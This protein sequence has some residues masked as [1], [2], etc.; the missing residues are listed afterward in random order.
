MKIYIVSR[1]CPDNKYKTFGIF[2]L[3]QAKAL[4][5]AGCDVV[6]LAV[7]VRSLRRWRKWG[8][9]QKKI[10]NVNIFIYSLPL[11]KIPDSIKYFISRIIL[12]KMYKKAVKLFGVP[13]VIHAHFYNMGYIAAK[14]KYLDKTPLVITEHSSKIHN[15]T[16][17]TGVKQ[18][19][20]FGYNKAS[21]VISVS[22]SVADHINEYFGMP[23][24]VIPN[25]IDTSIFKP[26]ELK[27]NEGFRFVCT[28]SLTKNKALDTLIEAFAK[29]FSE[30]PQVSLTIFGE[31]E[32]RNELEALIKRYKLEKQIKLPGLAERVD[33]A[34]VLAQSD[35][36]ILVSLSETFGVAYIEALAAG[37]P[38]IAA[39]CGGPED[40]INDENG[41]FVEKGD[42]SQT[43]SAMEYM[44]NNPGKY[45]KQ[46]ISEYIKGRY[47]GEIIAAQ[48][49]ECYKNVLETKHK[50]YKSCNSAI[51]A[52]C[53]N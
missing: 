10:D 48:L 22:K 36:F 44:V 52:G 14:S 47:S 30:C 5:K 11:G 12:D 42:I 40:F 51:S 34:K 7:D 27:R 21:C 35:C 46:T 23:S 2:E 33:I 1:G 26:Y 8:W 37:L 41:L 43:A 50:T 28:A 31:G 6:L 9:Q 49:I 15:T 24:V 32:M 29:A 13:D 18:Q 16:E 25:T 38:V 4:A 3:D 45:N 53:R 17:N 19:A 39:R 20:E